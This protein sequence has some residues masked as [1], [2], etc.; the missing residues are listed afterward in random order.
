MKAQ[1]FTTISKQL[2]DDV[3]G[4]C[5]LCGSRR[6]MEVHHIIPRCVATELPGFNIHDKDNL[7]VVC[8]SCHAKLTPRR[9]LIKYGI[10]K[11]PV[12]EGTQA[13][14]SQMRKFY[15]A[16]ERKDFYMDGADFIDLVE[17]IFADY[18]TKEQQDER[19]ERLGL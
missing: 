14:R 17:L 7:L 10:A 9:M 11:L 12:N 4:R 19:K 16:L 1:S 15:N 3:G 8:G 6:N 2:I 13:S 5:E 18:L